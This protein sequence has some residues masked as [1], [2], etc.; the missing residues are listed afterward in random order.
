MGFGPDQLRDKALLALEE[1]VTECRYGPA[2]RTIALRFALAYLWAYKPG[3]RAPFD[4]YWK[5]L[6]EPRSPWSF[7]AA[8]NALQRIY[9]VHGLKRD[10]ETGMRMWRRAEAERAKR[11]ARNGPGG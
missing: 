9:V 8:D 7:S 6:G 1:A 5:A 10:D 3:D 4:E 11:N 2:K